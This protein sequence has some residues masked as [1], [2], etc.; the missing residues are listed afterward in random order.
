MFYVF[1]YGI[2]GLMVCIGAGALNIALEPLLLSRHT[3]TAES[4]K[5]FPF[6]RMGKV[7][8]KALILY[9]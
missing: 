1:V 2:I 4:E 6:N 8:V 9:F 3:Q 7:F 5:L